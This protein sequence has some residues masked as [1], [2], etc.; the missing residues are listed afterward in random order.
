MSEEI[1]I[2]FGKSTKTYKVHN[3]IWKHIIVDSKK[4]LH[5]WFTGLEPSGRR[6]CTSERLLINPYNGCSHNCVFCYAHALWGYFELFRKK[7]VVTVFKDFDKVISKQL[8]KLSIASCGYISP[9]T[10]PFQPLNHKYKLT[11]KIIKEFVKRNIPVE[12][13]TKGKISNSAINL[14]KRQE[15][16]FG[17]VSILTLDEEI[18]SNL[19]IGGASTEELIKNIERLSN[20]NIFAVC[21]IDPIVP[22]LTNKKEDLEELV[23][24]VVEA[25]AK[26]IIASCMDIP[27]KLRYEIL[28]KFYSLGV[29]SKY[30]RLYTEKIGYNL[31]ANIAYR[32]KLFKKVRE[33]CDKY[34]VTMS[35]C[36]EYEIINNKVK[37]L[38]REFMSSKSCEGIEIPIYLRKGERFEP[39][40]NCDGNCLFCKDAVCGIQDLKKA[41]AWKLRDYKRWSMELRNHMQRRL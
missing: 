3:D 9:T 30:L 20:N 38:N 22:Y 23:K 21:R 2:T 7:G 36:M 17:Q 39:L 31:N 29:G 32:K 41:G 8:D 4:E 33:I 11:E 34:K 13:I 6:E 14:I 40:E 16:S 5:G 1:S 18:R 37:G 27:E 19:R 10:D 35:L 28:D 26:H 15:H 12:F 25:G 24:K